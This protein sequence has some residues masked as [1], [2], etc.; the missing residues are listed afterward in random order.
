MKEKFDLYFAGSQQEEVMAALQKRGYCKLFSFSGEKR[1]IEN[2]IERDKL[3]GKSGKLMIDSGAFSVYRRGATVDIDEY[4]K[5]INDNIDYIDLAIQLDKIPG[6]YK[7][8]KTKQQID[9]SIEV[10]WQNFLYM[11][12]RVTQPKKILPV[13]HQ[14]ESFKQLERMVNFKYEDGSYIDYICISCSKSIGY[15]LRLEWYKQCYDLINK[16]KNPYVKVHS[17]GNQTPHHV[18]QLPFT[19]ADATTW[20]KNAVLGR[21]ITKYGI[22][23][24]SKVQEYSPDNVDNIVGVET[25]KK[26]VEERGYDYEQLKVSYTQRLLFNADYFYERMVTNYNCVYDRGKGI[27][28]LF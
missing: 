2:W 26:Y 20:L 25:I 13:F 7:T 3:N 1:K 5:Y 9:E 4:I 6:V 24:V 12:E 18:E 27:A 21:I 23:L 17:L 10:T 16:S 8:K 14:W 28:R 22:F 11:V 15:D 19:S